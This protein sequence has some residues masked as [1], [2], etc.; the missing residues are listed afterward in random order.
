VGSDEHLAQLDE[1]A[2][3]LVVDLNETPGVFA[4]TDLAAIGAGDLRVGSDNSEGNLRH[5]LVVLR[6]GLVVVKLVAGTLE[7]LDVVVLDICKDLGKSALSLP[8]PG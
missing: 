2:V 8:K 3:L 1:I 6:D 5:D 4:S 7:D